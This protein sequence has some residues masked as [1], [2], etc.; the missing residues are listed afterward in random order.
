MSDGFRPKAVVE[1]DSNRLAMAGLSLGV[2]DAWE[3]RIRLSA[4]SKDE[5][6]LPV[7]HASTVPLKAGRGDYGSGVVEELTS[8]DVFVALLE[9]GPEAIDSALFS[10]VSAAPT[11]IAPEDLHP[12]QLQRV[13]PGQAGVQKFFT[14]NHRAFCLYVVIGSYA[15]AADLAEKASSL[16]RSLRID[17]VPSQ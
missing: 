10:P 6:V 16:L 14:V 1:N 3:A 7:L 12:R 5:V 11:K 2:P 15:L 13:I 17:S 4:P 8:Q 9:F